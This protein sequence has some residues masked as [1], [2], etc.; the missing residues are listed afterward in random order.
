MAR[1]ELIWD[2]WFYQSQLV[3]YQPL[4]SIIL[5]I[6]FYNVTCVSVLWSLVRFCLKEYFA[7][8][9]SIDIEK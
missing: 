7:E 9:T 8:S 3:F 2:K 4:V 6:V 5:I 1:N